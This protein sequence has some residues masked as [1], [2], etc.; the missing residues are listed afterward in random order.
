[1]NDKK[2]FH[3]HEPHHGHKK[4]HAQKESAEVGKAYTTAYKQHMQKEDTQQEEKV[5]Q[6]GIQQLEKQLEKAETDAK[7]YWDLSLRLRA[8]LE[9]LQ[10]RAEQNLEKAHKYGVEKFAEAMLP[11]VDSL[12]KGLETGASSDSVKLE[13]IQQGCE[14]TLK[15]LVDALKKFNIEPIDPLNQ[16]FNP[17]YHEAILMQESAGTAPGN[18]LAVIQK[19]YT[20]N[21]RVLRPARVIVAKASQ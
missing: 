4:E 13:A 10:R 17:E 1:M 18:I 2:H 8:E 5:V 6:E 14:L 7:E 11:V 12:E 15:M 9:N 19:G 16:P 20:L 3:D 21:G